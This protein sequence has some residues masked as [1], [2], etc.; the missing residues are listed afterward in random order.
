[1][2]VSSNTNVA[3]S[4]FNPDIRYRQMPLLAWVE[5][6]REVKDQ[7][8]SL[9]PH[10]KMEHATLELPQKEEGSYGKETVSSYSGEIV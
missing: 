10:L 6:T 9:S 2:E 5:L 4:S 1:L 8:V 7:G 3:Q